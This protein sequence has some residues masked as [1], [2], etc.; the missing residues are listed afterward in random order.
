MTRIPLVIGIY[1]ALNIYFGKLGAD[2]WA[3]F[4]NR[5][6]LFSG[7]APIQHILR[8]GQPGMMDVRRMLDSCACRH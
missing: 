7:L 5:G 4:E 1:K 3:T 2:R 6:P 8:H